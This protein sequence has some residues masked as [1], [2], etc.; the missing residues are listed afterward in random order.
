MVYLVDVL[1]E[2]YLSELHKK[3]VYLALL[4]GVKGLTEIG[5]KPEVRSSACISSVGVLDFPNIG[6]RI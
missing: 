4:S 3:G 5:K 1:V 2:A 6:G